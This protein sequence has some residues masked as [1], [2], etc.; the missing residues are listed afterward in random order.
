MK[1]ARCIHFSL[2]RREL[3]HGNPVRVD[4]RRKRAVEHAQ[5]FMSEEVPDCGFAVNANIDELKVHLQPCGGV[6]VEQDHGAR[7]VVERLHP[8][9]RRLQLLD[10]LPLDTELVLVDG[11]DFLVQQDLLGL[12]GNV[13]EIVG[14]QQWGSHDRPDRKL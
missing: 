6:S 8:E 9:L 5:V 12:V 10:S 1:V 14:H 11:N 3:Q 4:V 13:A 2:L 7:F